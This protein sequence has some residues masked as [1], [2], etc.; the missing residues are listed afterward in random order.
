VVI[1]GGGFAALEVALALRALCGA[2][3]ELTLISPTT[4][5]VN[6]PATTIEAFGDG[7]LASYDL[8][9]IAGELSGSFQRASVVSVA[10]LV[11][12]VRLDSGD[13]V[14]YDFLVLAVGA[15]ATAT[16]PGAMT[17]RDDGDIAHFA[18]LLDELDTGAIRRLVFTAPSRHVW[19]LP[20]YELAL[21][22]A[23]RAAER[24]AEVEISIVTPEHEPM[25]VFGAE[26]S[27][28]VATLLRERDIEFVGDCIPDRFDGGALSL[29]F[30]APVPADRVVT[31]PELHGRRI[32]GVP[33]DW[34]S[35]IPVDEC[36][37]VEARPGVF[38][39]GDATS[40]PIKQGGLAA[41]QADMV[42]Q[43]IAATLGVPAL[44]RAGSRWVLQGRLLHGE[45][46]LVLRTELDAFGRATGSAIEHR[47]SRAAPDL[48]VFGRYLTP[49]L[50]IYRAR[51]R[52]AGVG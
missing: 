18:A 11:R 3:I 42:A 2:R 27:D 41:Q 25:E 6:R 10:H 49:Y 19:T 34:S 30:D 29:Q 23:L 17:F 12:S 26:A 15:Q 4:S 39:A 24:S 7:P 21:R 46:A 28:A 16:I 8:L 13:G 5:L 44:A 36:G 32:A 33:A 14:D 43:T 40:F 51:S 52:E 38:A 20:I 48:K 9:T 31:V 35:F 45:G 50:S 47:E 22:S 1:A 37:R